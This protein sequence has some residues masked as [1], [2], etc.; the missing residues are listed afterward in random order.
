MTPWIRL[1]GP[2][3]I[4]VSALAPVGDLEVTHEWPEGGTALTF[5][6]LLPPTERPPQIVEQATCDLMI[7]ARPV[8]PGHLSEVNWATGQ[9]TAKGAITDGDSTPCLDATGKTTTIPDAAIDSAIT[10][11]EV[12]WTRPASI[13]AAAYGAAGETAALNSL[14]SMLVAYQTE[15]DKRIYVDPQRALRMGSDPTVPGYYLLPGTPELSWATEAQATRLIGRYQST[16]AGALANVT[17]T[18]A[19]AKPP[20]VVKLIDLTKRGVLTST[21][22]NAVLAGILRDVTS[23]AWAGGIPVSRHQIAG[24]P[25]LAEVAEAIGRGEMFRKLGQRDP[26]AGRVP[27]GFIDFVCG[28][29]VWRPADD[30]ITLTPVGTVARDWASVLEEYGVQE[31]AA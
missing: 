18:A 28:Q 7:G 12:T 23:G 20:Y 17:V 22:A 24:E 29:S 31:A 3:G 27:V 5:S 14:T 25:D 2:G 1:G 9:I 16:T 30:V 26:R 21:R 11:D 4:P 13:S 15:A 10:R 19:G 6:V 8:W